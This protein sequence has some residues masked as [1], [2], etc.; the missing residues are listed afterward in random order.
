MQYHQL[1]PPDK[2]ELIT[3]RLHTGFLQQIRSSF[4][5]TLNSRTSW[6]NSS[7]VPPVLCHRKDI[8]NLPHSIIYR[9]R[10]LTHW[11]SGTL[12]YL[13]NFSPECSGWGETGV[14]GSGDAYQ[15]YAVVEIACKQMTG[16]RPRQKTQQPYFSFCLCFSFSFVFFSW[17]LVLRQ[18][19]RHLS[20]FLVDNS[21]QILGNP[22]TK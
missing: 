10:I 13:F 18:S 9:P 16:I 2:S 6:H 17:I 12:F 15:W 1:Y 4:F 11:K 7:P 14:G 8:L 20:C 5:L 19:I 22:V 21:K 3:A